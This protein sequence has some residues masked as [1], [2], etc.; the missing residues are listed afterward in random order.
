[1][2]VYK[3]GGAS[4]N[5]PE[6]IRNV[7][8]IIALAPKPIVV[9]V[10]A[11]GKTTNA[12]EGVLECIMSRDE[13]KAISRLSAVYDFHDN[14]IEGLGLRPTTDSMI[15]E[16]LE[17]L[18]IQYSNNNTLSYSQ[19]YDIIVGYGE[20]LSSEIIAA[21]MR[22]N[23]IKTKLLNMRNLL[24]TDNRFRSAN[25]DMPKS[26]RR[27]Q[28]AIDQTADVYVTQG[29]IAGTVNGEPTTLGREGSD[30]SAAI[31]A[32][33]LNADRLTIWKDV[34]GVLNADPREMETA[35]LIPQLSYNDA[36]E[37]AYSGAQVIHPKTIRPLQNKKI[38][39]YVKSFINPNEKGSVINSEIS[40]IT[41]PIYII[42]KKQMLLSLAPRDFSFALESALE[43]AFTILNK[44]KESITIIQSSALQISVGIDEP[45]EIEELI[46]ELKDEFIVRY[47]SGLELVTIRG[48]RDKDIEEYSKGSKVYIKQQT[49]RIVRILKSTT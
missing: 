11:M 14:I 31:V 46:E 4:I 32:Y 7:F 5:T 36:V 9:I 19:L 12:L 39:L 3:F 41:I 34:E 8:Q 33:A 10:S 1:M 18:V 38:P 24:V 13:E 2:E 28:L 16:E 25:V 20:L 26:E 44:H 49:R 15:M 43:R 23:H 29:F 21:F 30:Y 47:N 22:A 37:L 6:R 42:K 35:E 17:Q 45:R 40:N 27:L 48:Y